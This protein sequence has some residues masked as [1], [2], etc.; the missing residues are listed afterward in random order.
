MK[1]C[2]FLGVPYPENWDKICDWTGQLRSKEKINMYN[3][4]VQALIYEN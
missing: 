1:G 3:Y 2:E 4:D